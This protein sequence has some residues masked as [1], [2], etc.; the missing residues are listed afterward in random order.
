M[1]MSRRLLPT[2]RA[3]DADKGGRGE[4][5]QQVKTG[6]PRKPPQS[7]QL[8]LS[9]PDS[10]VRTL[11][12]PGKAKA[13]KASGQDYGRSSPVLLARYDRDTRSWRTSQTS[14]VETEAGGFSEFLETW[15]RS[16]MTVNGIAYQL[17]PLVPLT[18]GT[19][20]GLFATPQAHEG[21]A[22]NPENPDFSWEGTY[23]RRADGT[24]K[25]T[26]LTDQVKMWPTPTQRDFKSDRSSPE[27]R[28]SRMAETRGKTL[29]FVV[30]GT[31][32]PMWV[33]WLMGYPI[34]WTDL[35][36]S[37]TP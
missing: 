25:Q 3:T 1:K 22:V 10:R 36:D 26:R 34:G 24:K 35:G 21:G 17:P 16:G 28:E 20:F 33:E 31:L 11:A 18:A 2:P 5:L 32:N 12:L 8:T 6:S 27:W 4:L 7:D 15:P 14:L 13:L 37:E 19:G 23:W 9:L 30:G 29:P